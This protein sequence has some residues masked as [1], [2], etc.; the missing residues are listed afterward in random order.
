M[1]P[2][3]IKKLIP[4]KRKIVTLSTEELIET[5]YLQPGH[6]SPL[7]I[8]PAVKD[9]SLKVWS[10]NNR[11]LIEAHLLRHGAIL[12]R[13][14]KVGTVLDFRQFIDAVSGQLL[15][16]TYRST[17]RTHLSE[18]IYTSTEYPANQFI[19]LHNEMSYARSWPMK[20]WFCCL[21]VAEQGG[22]TPLADSGKV[23]D[24]I[25]SRIR[26][27]FMKNEVMYVRN[28]GEGVDIPWQQVFGTTSKSAVE[29]YCRKVGMEFEWKVGD[30]LRTRQKCQAVA[31]HPMTGKMVWFNQAHLFHVTSLGQEIC[32][33][34]LE[35]FKEED[36]PRNAFFG[37]GSPIEA[38]I[39]DEIRDAYS[40]EEIIFPWRE[41]DILMLDNMLMAHGRTPYAGPRSI[42]VGM[43]EPS[44]S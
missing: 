13:D 1:N 42:V 14:F 32:D 40:Q 29:D 26:E 9:L 22:E 4:H 27:R 35:E 21:K 6:S 36:L 33:S 20:I 38:S 5:G 19:P 24:R 12:F 30:R 10:S 7:I 43:A 37:D 17:P 25:D 18:N 2:K 15:E 39:L 28:Y 23:F 34:L 8:K 16:Y 11:E 3:P 31:T 41:Q 44:G